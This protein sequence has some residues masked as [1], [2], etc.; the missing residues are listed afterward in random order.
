MFDEIFDLNWW[1]Q[2]IAGVAVFLLGIEFMGEGLKKIAGSKL[3]DL[4]DKFTATPIKGILVGM[5]ITV[6]IQSSSATTALVIGLIS[7]GIMTLRQGFGVIMG[8]DRSVFSSCPSCKTVPHFCEG[9]W[10]KND[11]SLPL[12]KELCLHG[13]LSAVCIEGNTRYKQMTCISVC[14]CWEIL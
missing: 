14:R 2:V 9:I 7:A 13:S 6:L 11:T 1:G 4:I 10:L 8:N 5:I 3:K 12:I